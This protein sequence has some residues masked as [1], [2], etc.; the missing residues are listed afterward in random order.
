MRVNPS[1]GRFKI[2][3]CRAKGTKSVTLKLTP[4][5][6]KGLGQLSRQEAKSLRGRLVVS[7]YDSLGKGSESARDTPVR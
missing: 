1:N 2:S 7:G 3:A 6:L 4:K 5:A